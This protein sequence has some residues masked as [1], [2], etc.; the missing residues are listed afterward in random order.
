MASLGCKRRKCCGG[1]IGN[2]K[3]VGDLWTIS[4]QNQAN[5]LIWLF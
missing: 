2:A 3:S 1:L 5:Q 4:G